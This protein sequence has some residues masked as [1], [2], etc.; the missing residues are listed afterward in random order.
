V[1]RVNLGVLWTPAQYIG[2]QGFLVILGDIDGDGKVDYMNI[3]YDGSITAW[4]NGGVGVPTFWQALGVVFNE[5][6]GLAWQQFR[7]VCASSVTILPA[8]VRVALCILKENWLISC[9]QILTGMVI[10]SP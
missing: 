1:Y 6:G 9:R 3:G 5:G 10:I 7:F 4:R 2:A 8:R